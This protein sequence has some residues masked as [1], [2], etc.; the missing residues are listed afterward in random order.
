M[1]TSTAK[2]IAVG[3]LVPLSSSKASS[4]GS[5]DLLHSVQQR[6]REASAG[7]NA[8]PRVSKQDIWL[9]DRSVGRL[10][11]TRGHLQPTAFDQWQGFYAAEVAA[12]SC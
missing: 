12:F 11:N 9:E 4:S 6:Q 1:K 7:S 10:Q 8:A 3:V 2:M 5:L